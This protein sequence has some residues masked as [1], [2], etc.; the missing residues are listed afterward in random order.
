MVWREE[1][2]VTASLTLHY[3]KA[4]FIL[5]PTEMSRKL[6][7]KRVSVCEYPDGRIEIRH[8]D[9]VLPYRVFDKMRQVNQAAVI[10]NKH[11]D[12]ALM[13]ARAFQ[14]LAHIIAVGTTTSRRAPAAPGT[15]L[16]KAR[17]RAPAR[18]MVGGLA[19]PN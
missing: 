1:R 17:A 14:E 19:D 12:A 18:S 2:S 4:M 3:N 11:L 6:A 15:F 13:M 7:R 8:G 9:H 16:H 5:E 10:D